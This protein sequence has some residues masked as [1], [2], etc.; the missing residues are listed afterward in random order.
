[1]SQPAFVTR[2]QAAAAPDQLV[3]A[4]CRAAYEAGRPADSS[5]PP[6]EKTS[7]EWQDGMHRE[8][9]AALRAVE[10]AGYRIVSP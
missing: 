3:R 8:M 4:M 7:P 9:R 6:F 2:D 5:R 1:M 10:A